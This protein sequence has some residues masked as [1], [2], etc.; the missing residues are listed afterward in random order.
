LVFDPARD[1]LIRDST[2]PDISE[3]G[4]GYDDAPDLTWLNRRLRDLLMQAP[5]AIGITAGP[6]HR[7][8][9]VNLARA[10]M[11]GRTGIE[12]FVGKVVRDSYPELVGQPF[13]DAL[14][15]VYRTGVPFV[16]KEIKGTFS[17][18]PGGTPDVAYLDCVYQ[19][20]RN[21]DGKVE[22]L[23]IH[24]VEVT[25]QVLARHEIELA[26]KREKEQRATAEFERNQLRE[27]FIQAPAGIAMLTGPEHRWSF[28]NS[29]YCKVLGRTQE[30]LLG[31]TIRET[32]PELAGQ[33]FFELLDQAYRSGVAYVG[34]DVKAVLNRGADK[35]PEEAY[36]DFIYQ[37]VRNMGGEVEGLMALAVEITEQHVA[38]SELES[39]VLDRTL[40][41][42]LAREALQVLSG[43]LMQAQDDE[44]RR[45]ARELHE[46]VG[47]YLAAI[48]MN[49]S[50]VINDPS[51][52][53]DGYRSRLQASM[54]LV[55]HCTSEIRTIS[56]LLHPP[57]LDD[58]GLR[59]AISWYV[60]GFTERTG[61]AVSLDIP[62]DLRRFSADVETV[63]FRV[64]QQSLANIH[65]H[66][67]SKAGRVRLALVGGRLVVEISDEG[68][69]LD[70]ATLAKFRQSGQIPGVGLSG[71]RERINSLQGTFDIL[72]DK[73]GTTIAVTLPISG[74]I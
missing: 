48:Q 57:L 16:G 31:R 63:T 30:E 33:G 55:D 65:R 53:D 73:S 70:A 14:D 25:E 54:K 37:P 71:M 12:D 15:E 62:S 2:Q 22:G 56:Y 6:E 50:A 11:A 39:R 13:F 51:R 44:R 4:G 28:A 47:Q 72:S 43:R 32:L 35:S 59:S 29:S 40:E 60:D 52:P 42:R 26:N 46:S 58:V 38:R 66:S 3:K 9:Y 1:D 8:A 21:P 7:W 17:R 61:V 49:L 10:R 68:R 24:T 5:S 45:V 74:S 67:D 41:L 20:I 18:G 23:L 64:V 36:F 19:P 34:K 27:L 69:G